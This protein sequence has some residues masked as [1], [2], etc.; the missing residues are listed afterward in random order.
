MEAGS[1][2]PASQL[3]SLLPHHD[4]IK[5]VFDIYAKDNGRKMAYSWEGAVR[6]LAAGIIDNPNDTEL[7]YD[8][9][10]AFGQWDMMKWKFIFVAHRI[11]PEN[12]ANIEAL[13]WCIYRLGDHKQAIGLVNKALATADKD[14][15]RASL[16]ESKMRMENQPNREWPL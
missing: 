4:D 12:T 11:N 10:G 2:S 6:R 14:A 13:A 1:Y 15:D 16:I 8:L 3:A 5:A 7:W 9:A